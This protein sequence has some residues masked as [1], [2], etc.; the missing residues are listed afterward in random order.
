MSGYDK[1]ASFETS[2]VQDVDTSSLNLSL[3]NSQGVESLEGPA[4]EVSSV[5]FNLPLGQQEEVSFVDLDSFDFNEVWNYSGEVSSGSLELVDSSFFERCGW[6]V[7]GNVVTVGEY[8]YNIKNHTLSV[9]GQ[10]FAGVFISVP[11]GVSDYSTLNTLTMLTES[12]HSAKDRNKDVGNFSNCIVASFTN[13]DSD[14]YTKPK[15][16][17]HVTKFMNQVAGTDLSKC[18]NIITGGSRLGARSLKIAAASGDLYQT[19]ICVN[20]AVLVKG[21]N[22]IGRGKECFENLDS[23][24][25]LDGKNVYFIS[26]KADGNFMKRGRNGDES[27]PCYHI[28]EGYVYTGLNI[29]LENCPNANF[30]FISNNDDPAFATISSPNYHYANAL[31]SKVAASNDYAEH[32]T[33]HDILRDLCGSNLINFNGYSV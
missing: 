33:F 31:W 17:A 7:N 19:A 15:N 20:N 25:G 3:Q 26:S 14:I 13:A 8:S 28:T 4:V 1:S 30:Y 18:Q 32:K 16:V 12:G 9:N 22:S 6:P 23:L 27:D 2:Q 21:L 5:D 29:A 10:V 11:S 24:K